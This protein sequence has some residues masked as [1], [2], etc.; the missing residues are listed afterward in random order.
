[1][2]QS[3]FIKLEKKD[4]E[5]LLPRFEK[6]FEGA[7]FTEKDTVILSQKSGFYP[8]YIFYD[9]ADY[10]AVPSLHRYVVAKD[11]DV[12][13]LDFTNEPLYALN[14]KAPLTLDDANV[15]DYVRFFFEYVRGRDGRFIIVDSVDDIAWT[16]D[17]P[18]AVRKAVNDIVEPLHAFSRDKSGAYHLLACMT[19][20]DSLFR[21]KIE[22]QPDGTV[23][24]YDEEMALESLPV[25]NDI[26]D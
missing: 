10:H 3:A 23:L 18:A 22:V 15:A 2:V 6:Y 11:D 26:L 8:G 4:V 17:P 25:A 19:F 16:E 20:K 24:V 13:V 9:I 1:M 7:H 5:T 21:C 12:T 14:K